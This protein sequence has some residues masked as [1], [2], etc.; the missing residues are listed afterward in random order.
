MIERK[1][2]FIGDYQ[3]E[4]RYN[5]KGGF[6]YDTWY[7]DGLNVSAEEIANFY[8]VDYYSTGSQ[9]VWLKD[10]VLHRE[11]GPAKID[12]VDSNDK[13]LIWSDYW[14]VNGLLH[15]EDGPAIVQ[16]DDFGEVMKESYYLSGRKISVSEHHAE[17]KKRNSVNVG[18]SAPRI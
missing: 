6:Q 13:L 4:H 2:E 10:G 7:K 15:R 9:E 12:Y 8:G 11:G 5:H 16:Y 14:Y 1:E 17:M 18:N 3:V